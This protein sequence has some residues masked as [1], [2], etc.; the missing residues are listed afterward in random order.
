MDIIIQSLGFKAGE[1][2]EAFVSEKLNTLKN[3]KIIRADVTLFKG[4][5]SEADGDYC[6]I[7]L[8]MPG[9]DPFV[10]RHGAHFETAVSEC[11]DALSE[12]LNRTKS[13]DIK[14][15]QADTTTIQDALME[16]EEDADTNVELEDVVKN[17]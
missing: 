14:Q 1:N 12:I 10:K 4:P 7:R 9:N 3:D 13:R 17:P 8:E 5:G 16:G 2:L 6:E 15:R 11:V